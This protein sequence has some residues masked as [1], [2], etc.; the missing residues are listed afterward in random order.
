[1]EAYIGTIMG[2]AP[3]FAPR[4]WAFCAGQILPIAQYSAVF[5]LLGTMYG[6]NGVQTFA[7]PNLQGR[8]PIGAGQSPG[9]S[10]Y[11]QGEMSGVENTTLL[12][13]QMP[14]H[15][16]VA[17]SNLT[18]TIPATTTAATATAPS[19]TEIFAAPNGATDGGENVTVK[20]YGAA[21]SANTTLQGGG[22]TGSITIGVAGGSQPVSILQPYQ[23]IQYVICLEGIFPPRP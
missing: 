4:G 7:L 1:M 14:M 18:T 3:N 21:T 11:T 22:V 9:T 10:F 19:G 13:S 8:V 20:A 2:W 5:S 6:G 23:V 12:Q 15:T 16:H 17:Q